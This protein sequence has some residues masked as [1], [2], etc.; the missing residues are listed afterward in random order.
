MKI[1]NNS[2]FS[3]HDTL[4]VDSSTQH[5]AMVS[6]TSLAT[7]RSVMFSQFAMHHAKRLYLHPKSSSHCV[8]PALSD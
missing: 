1:P 7:P 8:H 2:F 3:H 6:T 4:L 5:F